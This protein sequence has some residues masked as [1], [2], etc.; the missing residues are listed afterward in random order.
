MAENSPKRVEKTEKRK[1]LLGTSKTSFPTAFSKDLHCRHI[2][3]RACLKK[4]SAKT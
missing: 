1:N 3:T 2:K 4:G